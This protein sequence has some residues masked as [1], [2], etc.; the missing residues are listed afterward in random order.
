MTA[1]PYRRPAENGSV[2]MN[3]KG[4]RALLWCGLLAVLVAY[5]L[6][7]RLRSEQPLSTEGRTLAD[8]VEH[9]HQRGVQLYVIPAARQGGPNYQGYLTEDPDATWTSLQSKLRTVE[10]IDQW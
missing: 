4:T 10:H 1:L 5:L 6:L 7:V 2:P 9:V 3:R 8:F